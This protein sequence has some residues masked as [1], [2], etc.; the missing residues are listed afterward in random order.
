MNQIVSMW[1]SG[2]YQ[3]PAEIAMTRELVR[4]DEPNNLFDTTPFFP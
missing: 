4:A 1:R 2:R 3:T